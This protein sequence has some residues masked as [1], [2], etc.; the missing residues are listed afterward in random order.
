MTIRAVFL[1]TVQGCQ[2]TWLECLWSLWGRLAVGRIIAQPQRD[3]HGNESHDLN[4]SFQWNRGFET[5]FHF[6]PHCSNEAKYKKI[7]PIIKYKVTTKQFY[8]DTILCSLTFASRS[9]S[10]WK[11]LS[12]GW[13]WESRLADLRPCAPLRSARH[14]DIPQWHWKIFGEGRIRKETQ[15]IKTGRGERERLK[16]DNLP[17]EAVAPRNV[18]K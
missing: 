2:L 3:P 10:M 1:W 14:F 12:E 18:H 17:R 7:Y 5:P 6:S 11:F 4:T 8:W 15:D 16:D 13:S 9:V